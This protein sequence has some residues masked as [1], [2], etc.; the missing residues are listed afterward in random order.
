MKMNKL[1]LAMALLMEAGSSFAGFVDNRTAD[2]VVDV[3]YKSVSV[4]DLVA[5]IVP[6]G[7]QTEYA[8]PFQRKTLV[9]ITGKGMWST[10]LTDAV[11]KSNLSVYI[12]QSTRRIKFADRSAPVER[13]PVPVAKIS[14][15][16]AVATAVDAQV[17]RQPFTVIGVSQVPAGAPTPATI[18]KPAATLARVPVSTPAPT[19]FT[20][21]SSDYQVSAVLQRWAVQANMQYIW[22][23]RNVEFQVSAEN[24]WGTDLERAVRDLLTS[25]Q[26]NQGARAGRDRVRA[27]IHPNKPKQVLRIIRFEE[28]C[29]GDM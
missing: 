20:T 1:V 6:A 18:V 9:T 19:A 28:R 16:P 8:N 11:A 26:A 5:D 21:T 10:L 27:C 2:A 14:P 29:E 7:Y 15:A 4:E 13:S 23:P 24:D 3:N 22:E 17:P 12:D 25:V